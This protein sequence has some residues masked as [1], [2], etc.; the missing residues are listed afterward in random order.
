MT[1]PHPPAETPAPPDGPAAVPGA[2]PAPRVPVPLR[3]P[4]TGTAAE[5][6]GGAP[7]SGG[8]GRG[9]GAPRGLGRAALVTAVLSVAGS[10]LGLVRDQTIAHL[11]G[12]GSDTDAFLVSWTVPEVAS[13]LLIED[14]M[15]LVLVPAF[16]LA[17]AR[18]TVRGLARRTLP[19]MCLALGACAALL[20]FAAP[21]VVDALAPGLPDHSLAVSCTRLTATCVFSFGLVGYFS[22]ALRAH[23][24]FVAPAAIYVAYNAGIVAVMLVLPERLGVRA[25]AAG[26][27]VG[28]VCMALVQ[29]PSLWRRFRKRPVSAGAVP[30]VGL[31]LVAPVALFALTRQSQVLVERFLAAPLQAGAIS[32]LNYAQK[33][34][35]LPMS[36]SLMLCTVTFPVVARAMD[37]GDTATA[38]R[39]V[40]RDLAL[41]AVLVLLGTALVISCAPQIVQLLF[42]R[43]AFG[44]AD[45]KA[46]AS[47]MRVYALGLL[48]QTL[49]GALVRCYF[50]AAK[51]LW[52]PTG[53]MLA[54]LALTTLSGALLVHVWGVLGI[55]AA[56]AIGITAAAALLL[57]G[58]RTRSVPVRVG[59]TAGALAR[60]TA[61]ACAAT[62]AGRLCA[63]A[64]PSPLLGTALACVAIAAV[65]LG[66]ARLLRAPGADT[67]LSTL[68]SAKR[69]FAHAR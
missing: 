55:A 18:G 8:P 5:A 6:A 59:H 43:G 9:G 31:S 34:A 52:Y 49:V 30:P 25:A 3:A 11:F 7:S 10:V 54:G 16:S 4:G 48:G 38:R 32:H 20:A 50:Y 21:W 14:A 60:L 17:V 37:A 46:T 24:S 44:A 63:A 45:T 58:L 2:A 1:P 35:Q 12:A 62:G 65:F 64:V 47:V 36:L 67:F 39:R 33:V 57:G 56:N 61:A 27:A 66:T 51:P 13:T 15:A 40:E 26:V 42:Q 69:K 53:A 28:G 19:A 22:A 41:A 29:L 23:S 68:L